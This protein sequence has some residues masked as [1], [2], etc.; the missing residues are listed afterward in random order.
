[1]S[2]QINGIAYLVDPLDVKERLIGDG[3]VKCELQLY[4]KLS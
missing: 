1:M 3:D 4:V 2:C